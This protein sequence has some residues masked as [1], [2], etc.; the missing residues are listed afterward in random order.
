MTTNIPASVVCCDHT[1][2]DADDMSINEVPWL[3]AGDPWPTDDTVP[4]PD[5]EE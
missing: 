3:L 1:H 4:P 5:E 2:P